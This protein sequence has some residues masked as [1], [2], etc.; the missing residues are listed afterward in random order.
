MNG[1]IVGGIV[2]LIIGLILIPVLVVITINP[3][4]DAFLEFSVWIAFAIIGCLAGGII[5]IVKGSLKPKKKINPPK[6]EEE[7]KS[8]TI[9]TSSPQIL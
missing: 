4:Y 6:P 2:L 3:D 9:S 1:E 8:K 5:F 7:S